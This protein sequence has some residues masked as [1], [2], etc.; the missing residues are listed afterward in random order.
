MKNL[1]AK[2][3][4]LRNKILALDWSPDESY[5]LNGGLVKFVSIKKMKRQIAPLYYEVG[6]DFNFNMLEQVD[7]G[8]LT[9]VTME[10]VLTDVDTGISQTTRIIAEAKSTNKK[11]EPNDKTMEIAQAYALRMYYTGK[12]HIIDGIEYDSEGE[13]TES[14]LEASAVGPSPQTRLTDTPR[15]VPIPVTNASVPSVPQLTKAD[16]SKVAPVEVPVV[17]ESPVSTESVVSEKPKGRDVESNHRCLSKTEQRAIEN[18]FKAIT[19]F[20]DAGQ[21]TDEQFATAKAL[22]EQSTNSTDVFNLMKM[23]TT[24]EKSVKTALPKW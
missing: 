19:E 21:I 22:W 17:K 13:S 7:C 24:Y 14:I 8:A 23:K 12:Y 18:A 1:L 2:I 11:G 9:R 5:A 6:I 15:V 20:H 4:N 10:I 3:H 16:E